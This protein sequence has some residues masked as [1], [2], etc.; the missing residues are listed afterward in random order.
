MDASIDIGRFLFFL[1]FVAFAR[2]FV[3]GGCL[4]DDFED[5]KVDNGES[6]GADDKADAGIENGFLRLFYFGGFTIGGDVINA[7]DDDEHYGCKTKHRNDGV[8]DVGDVLF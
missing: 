2:V 5:D 3:V 1:L 4:T 6:K 8:E 7:A